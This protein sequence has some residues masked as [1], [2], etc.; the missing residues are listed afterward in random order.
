MGWNLWWSVLH[1]APSLWRSLARQNS[2]VRR[3]SD[4][5]LM[6]PCPDLGSRIALTA[7]NRI[8][9]F[10]GFDKSA[11]CGSSSPIEALTTTSTNERHWQSDCLR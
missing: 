11:S 1:L 5:V 10:D 4:K 6:A 3:Y 8:D 2:V 9:K 7:W